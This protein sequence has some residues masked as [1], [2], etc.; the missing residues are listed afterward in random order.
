MKCLEAEYFGRDVIAV[1]STGYRKSLIFH[2]LPSLFHDKLTSVSNKRA[3]VIVVNTLIENQIKKSYQENIKVGILNVKEG[4]DDEDLRLN[5]VGTDLLLKDAMY[6]I[7]NMHHKAFLS[8]KEG[9]EL[10]QSVAYQ[11]SV[12][13]VIVDEAHCILEW[14]GVKLE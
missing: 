10:L 1:L 7:I 12:W 3:V 6:D 11:E 13:A 14:Y 2:L 4:K 5:L 8:C 9:M